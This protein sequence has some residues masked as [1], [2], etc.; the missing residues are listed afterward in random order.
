MIRAT[1]LQDISIVQQIAKIS[2]ND[3]YKNIIPDDVQEL[4]LNKAYSNTML[5][6]RIE[7]TIFLL[8]E[9][10]G[11]AIGFANFTYV[12]EDGD[13]EL[14]AIYL[15]PEYQKNGYGNKLLH[16]GLREMKN[17]QQLYVYVES[18]NDSARGFYENFGF[19]CLEEFD[20]Y[21]EGHSISTAKYVLPVKTPTS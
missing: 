12:D 9:T 4:F 6:K 7:K 21:F 11:K 10:E 8:A 20:E 5:A 14:T 17:V 1:T 16:A 18:K 19:E 2:W 3:A 15:L 13:S